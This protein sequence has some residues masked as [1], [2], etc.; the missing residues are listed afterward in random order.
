MTTELAM[1]NAVLK[2]QHVVAQDEKINSDGLDKITF[3]FS[4]NKGGE[5]KELG[6]VASGGELSRLMLVIKSLLAGL[7]SLPTIIF[8]E[9]DTGISGEVASRV[10]SIMQQIAN[11]HQVIAI[12][13]LP[14]IAGKGSSHFVVYKTDT[15]S[16]T[17]TGMKMLTPE[18]RVNEIAR[19]LSGQ[20]LTGAAIE[21]AKDLL[22]I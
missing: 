10:G 19:M 6:K 5:F 14:Q 3:L 13:H 12:T 18:E 16:A 17:L 11:K 9:I 4:A 21:H 1:P 2:V 15:K 20:K 22:S 7:T 8:D